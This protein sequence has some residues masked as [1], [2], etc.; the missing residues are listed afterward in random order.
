MPPP[1]EGTFG[2][3]LGVQL[4]PPEWFCLDLLQQYIAGAVWNLVQSEGSGNSPPG[5]SCEN[6]RGT[7]MNVKTNLN[8]PLQEDNY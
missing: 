4:L 6:N 3:L 2:P 7:L 5:R 1:D 8:T